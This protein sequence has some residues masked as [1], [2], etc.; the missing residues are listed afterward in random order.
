MSKKRSQ[1][2]DKMKELDQREVGSIARTGKSSIYRNISATSSGNKKKISTFKV[3][4][5]SQNDSKTKIKHKKSKTS[6][7][8]KHLINSQYS[9]EAEVSNFIPINEETYQ[10]P[11]PPKPVETTPKEIDT[12]NEKGKFKFPPSPEPSKR[13]TT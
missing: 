6:R 10:F 8:S 12:M 5:D 1:S 2:S 3:K 11:G 9:S 4:N 13:S 7:L